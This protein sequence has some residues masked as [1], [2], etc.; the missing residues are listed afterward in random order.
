MVRNYI[1]LL[2]STVQMAGS[3]PG[4]GGRG[5]GSTS[6]DH[7]VTNTAHVNQITIE[8][9]ATDAKGIMA[10]VGKSISYIFTSYANAGLA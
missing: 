8:T 2:R 1:D 3:T 6:N 4:G 10:D 7:S 9:K 5:G